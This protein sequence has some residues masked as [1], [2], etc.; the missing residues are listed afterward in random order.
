MVNSITAG[1]KLY[2]FSLAACQE[3]GILGILQQRYSCF[4]RHEHF[5]H[6]PVLTITLEGTATFPA[7]ARYALL[8]IWE[9]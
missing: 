3:Q 7:G 8:Q 6:E 2:L 4:I 9:L 1:K 5:L